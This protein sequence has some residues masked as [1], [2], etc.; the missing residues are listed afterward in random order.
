MCPPGRRS[1]VEERKEAVEN[2]D[3]QEFKL[4]QLN[5]ANVIFDNRSTVHL[6]TY[7][8]RWNSQLSESYKTM[9]HILEPHTS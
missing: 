3:R 4:E 6:D 2:L 5:V 7:A 9:T 1:T 8:R